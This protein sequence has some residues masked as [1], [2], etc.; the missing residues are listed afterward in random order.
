M[1]PDLPCF[2]GG[3]G[4]RFRGLWRRNTRR[5]GPTPEENARV[6]RLP[7]AIPGSKKNNAET[8]TSN[9]FPNGGFNEQGANQEAR[10]RLAT[11]VLGG[12]RRGGPTRRHPWLPPYR[13]T[14]GRT[15]Q[16]WLANHPA[17][18]RHPSTIRGSIP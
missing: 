14:P 1:L 9:R 3:L 12:R 10:G 15:G 2:R 6:G 18:P 16:T 11:Q 4:I 17:R 13:P 5:G 8:A 7:G